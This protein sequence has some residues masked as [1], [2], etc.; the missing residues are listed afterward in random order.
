[1]VSLQNPERIPPFPKI[2]VY[3]FH[4]KRKALL[5]Y[6]MLVYN[7]TG[8]ASSLRESEKGYGP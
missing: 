4:E 2:Y 5:L 6:P 7:K 3:S 8:G 1:M